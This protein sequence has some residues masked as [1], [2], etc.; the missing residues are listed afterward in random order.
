MQATRPLAAERL[1]GALVGSDIQLSN[2][3]IELGERTRRVLVSAL[4]PETVEARL[5]EALPWLVA[6]Y[7]I[8]TGTGSYR[9]RS[10][11]T[12]RIDWDSWSP[13]RSVSPK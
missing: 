12:C 10:C 11:T 1:A 13:S 8:S 5:V 7:L 2:T 4:L 9:K 3:C 6:R